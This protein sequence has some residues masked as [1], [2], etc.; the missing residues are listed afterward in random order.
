MPKLV[1]MKITKEERDK[2]T[3]PSSLATDGPAYPYGLTVQLDNDSLEKLGIKTLPDAGEKYTLIAA[4]TVVGV[5]SSE[6]ESGKNRSVSLQLTALCLE[7]EAPG[8]LYD[9]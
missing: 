3:E 1:S 6:S 7:D 9:K 4:V 8:K 5:S 2:R